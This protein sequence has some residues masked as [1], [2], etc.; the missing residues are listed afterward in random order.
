M[1]IHGPGIDISEVNEAN[2]DNWSDNDRTEANENIYEDHN[3]RILISESTQHQTRSE[4]LQSICA[5]LRDLVNR[6]DSD[7]AF[8][9]FCTRP[10][11]RDAFKTRRKRKGS[12][13][14]L[15]QLVVDS[16][17]WE[18]DDISK[19]LARILKTPN[20]TKTN[21]VQAGSNKPPVNQRE[22]DGLLEEDHGNGTPVFLALAD[23]ASCNLNFIK[24]LLNLI[25]APSNLGKVFCKK[26]KYH[27][28]RYCLHA[29]LNSETR[30]RFEY[31][32]KIIDIM[33]SYTSTQGSRSENPFWEF[34]EDGDT[35]LHLVI[36][37]APIPEK[38][39]MGESHE[40]SLDETQ[41]LKTQQA[42]ELIKKLINSYPD[43]LGANKK[44]RVRRSLGRTPYQERIF[45]LAKKFKAYQSNNT[46]KGRDSQLNSRIRGVED[47]QLSIRDYLF[48]D[49]FRKFVF[50]DPVASFISYYCIRNLPRETASFYL[51]RPGEELATEFDLLGFPREAI[52]HSYLQHLE[53]HVHFEQILKYV[54]LPR[55]TYLASAGFGE[56]FAPI[57]DWLYNRQVRKIEKVTV[58]EDVENPHPD[59][60]IVRCL[61]RFEVEIWD[62]EK[63]DISSKV[64][65]RSSKSIRE[66]RLHSSGN[67]AVWREWCA[68]NGF[69]NRI[70]FPRLSKI[71]VSFYEGGEDRRTLEEYGTELAA[72]LE[73]DNIEWPVEKEIQINA[74]QQLTEKNMELINSTMTSRDVAELEKNVSNIPHLELELDHVNKLA[75]T[76]KS[77][78]Y[79]D[80]TDG[81]VVD[82]TIIPRGMRDGAWRGINTNELDRIARVKELTRFFRNTIARKQEYAEEG[83]DI[84]CQTV[85]IAII[86]DGIDPTTHI[87][88]NKY[89]RIFAGNSFCTSTSNS[90]SAYY[91][92][93]GPHGT[94][95]ASLI[96]QFCPEVDFYIAKIDE[97]NIR[98]GKRTISARSAARAI[99]WA[100]ACGVDI[101]CMG[102]TIEARDDN[103]SELLALKYATEIAYQRGIIMFCSS[104]DQRGIMRSYPG[105]WH[106]YGTS[107]IRIGSSPSYNALDRVDKEQAD[108]LLPGENILIE[109]SDGMFEYQTGSSYSTAIAVGLA[110]LLLYSSLVLGLG[111]SPSARNI[112][113][114]NNNDND[115]VEDDE[116]GNAS[117]ESVSS[118]NG[119]TATDQ[120]SKIINW[121]GRTM[122]AVFR[123]M[124]SST[125]RN[126]DMVV[127]PEKNIIGLIKRFLGS[128]EGLEKLH[129]DKKFQDALRNM[130]RIL[131]DDVSDRY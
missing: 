13:N 82:W 92:P 114:D 6:D 10:E 46:G 79:N 22:L 19:V 83:I 117:D 5:S 20:D 75:A 43:T 112:G 42:L 36:R 18:L 122:N 57:F 108:F 3:S 113:D 81:I 2:Q 73:N 107:C 51:Y 87:V 84:S 72:S 71:H 91:V 98:A 4:E 34:N 119:T 66:I 37:A 86:D 104:S 47:K 106:Q 116:G 77:N 25:P 9:N 29:M 28:E 38:Q 67:E 103:D 61:K 32:K 130:L 100:I 48:R 128:G 93:N 55:L 125:G 45:L 80:Q 90:S 89:T 27:R 126:Y 44:N 111:K 88:D 62:W 110:G 1:K 94:R 99:E 60:T 124:T 102:W 101:I 40:R 53:A 68:P 70:K 14:I 120:E 95:I 97:H 105:A 85:K 65:S 31:I 123:Q 39:N 49:D 56:N 26:S 59:S 74:L 15:H 78:S 131:T 63:M 24:A 16:K 11:F 129:W 54:A 52:D 109:G 50:S 8:E 121:N 118:R 127:R 69:R 17:D 12:R 33:D 7:K 115:D 96:N 21:D 76:T 30:S 35:P 41:F 64:I 58:I 23:G